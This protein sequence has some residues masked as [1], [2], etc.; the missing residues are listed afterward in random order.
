MKTG[1]S[2]R[3]V[4]RVKKIRLYQC[5]VLPEKMPSFVGSETARCS[6]CDK[7]TFEVDL[8][9]AEVL[10]H[11]RQG[12][13]VTRLLKSLGFVNAEYFDNMTLEEF[14]IL[15]NLYTQVMAHEFN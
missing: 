10:E 14:T 4:R 6:C 8:N 12:K 9:H 15:G 7:W 1:F 13:R 2:K 11:R 3:K 5:D